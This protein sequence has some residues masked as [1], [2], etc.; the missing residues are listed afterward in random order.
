MAS[1]AAWSG[2]QDLPH[3]EG[4]TSVAEDPH[5]LTGFGKTRYV[6][7][8]SVANVAWPG[9]DL[10][11]DTAVNLPPEDLLPDLKEGLLLDRSQ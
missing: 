5:A 11:K 8:M 10:L 7:A 2:P 4:R 9:H 3:G 1:A 6:R